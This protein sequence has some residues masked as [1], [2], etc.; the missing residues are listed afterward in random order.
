MLWYGTK[1]KSFTS[2]RL[3]RSRYWVSQLS[4]KYYKMWC[5]RCIG[6]AI[7]FSVQKGISVYKFQDFTSSDNTTELF[8]M[9][10][11]S[12]KSITLCKWLQPNFQ[13]LDWITPYNNEED[14][15]MVAHF[16]DALK[17]RV[18]HALVVMVD[19][20]MVEVLKKSFLFTFQALWVETLIQRRI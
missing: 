3:S 19:S 12:L 2:L 17:R 1:T 4:A 14:S 15:H 6:K 16:I 5:E 7:K 10:S 13:K 11:S 18:K 9:I 20:D 8:H